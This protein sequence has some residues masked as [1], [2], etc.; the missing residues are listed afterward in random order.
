MSEPRRDEVRDLVVRARREQIVGAA[1]RV[2]AEKGFRRATTKEVARAAGVSE[3]TIYNYFEDK[4]ALLLAI[5][6]RLNET[7]RRAA[8]FEEGMATDFRGFLEQY[9]RRRMSLIWENREVFRVVLSEMLVNAELRDRYV[10]H[11]VD[12]TMRIAEENF[13]SRME[14]GEVRETDTPLAMR[15]VAGAVLGILVLGLLGDEEIGSRS[16]EVPDVL[17][18]LLIHGLG[19]AEEEDRRG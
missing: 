7:E 12:P 2:F 19:A 1:T 16:D 10:R 14:Q 18:G 13:R 9:L 8:D 11:V 3:G 5:L 17:A 6:D 15:S 4:D